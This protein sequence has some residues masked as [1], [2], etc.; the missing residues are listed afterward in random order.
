[1]QIIQLQ[2]MGGY[3]V[4]DILLIQ[5]LQRF[6]IVSKRLLFFD[7]YGVHNLEGKKEKASSLAKG[8]A[9]KEMK[10]PDRQ[11]QL[12]GAQ[13]NSKSGNFVVVTS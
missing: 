12:V 1:M 5:N 11:N 7:I 9:V 13:F 4:N 2:S 6:A 10:M 3:K 8:P